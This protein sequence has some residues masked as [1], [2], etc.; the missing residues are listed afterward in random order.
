MDIFY[1]I[2]KALYISLNKGID[3][4][5]LFINYSNEERL[6]K[7]IHN[8]S[9]ENKSSVSIKVVDP[10]ISNKSIEIHGKLLR[11]IVSR[12]LKDSEIIIA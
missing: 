8:T 1:D 11:V 9:K 7:E 6:L 2:T 10:K 12:D 5:Y 3:P 4:K